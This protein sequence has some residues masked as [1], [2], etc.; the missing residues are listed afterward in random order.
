VLNEGTSVGNVFFLPKGVYV[1]KSP[2]PEILA[3]IN[4]GEK[5]EK[6]EKKRKKR[7]RKRKKENR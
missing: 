4:F 1:R 5:S 6:V 3:D 7:K 2:P